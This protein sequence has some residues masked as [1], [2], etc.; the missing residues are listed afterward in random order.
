V[1][2]AMRASGKL[3]T[4]DIAPAPVA[5]APVP[6]IAAATVPATTAPITLAVAHLTAAPRPEWCTR[7]A[8][9]TEASKAYVAQVCGQ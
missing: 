5:Q 3:C 4:A 6:A 9:T 7:A 8:P 1:R 2:N